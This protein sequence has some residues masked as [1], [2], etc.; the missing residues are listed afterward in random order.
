MSIKTY[1][2]Q[3]ENTPSVL[4]CSCFFWIRPSKIN[5]SDYT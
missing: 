1:S 2:S 5:V 4:Q 3:K